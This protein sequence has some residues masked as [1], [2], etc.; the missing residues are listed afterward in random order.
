[1]EIKNNFLTILLLVSV[2]AVA[3][4]LIV[5][6]NYAE[7][8]TV[9][10]EKLGS[11]HLTCKDGTKLKIEDVELDAKTDTEGKWSGTLSISESSQ[12]A[13]WKINEGKLSGEKYEFK[14]TAEDTTGDCPD[15]KGTKATVKGS[16]GDDVSIKLESEVGTVYDAKA[17]VK[18]TQ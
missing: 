8:A 3:T 18:C 5:G 15:E 4:H 7:A 6:N 11:G 2:F 1:M 10:T 17:T 9:K 13:D 12:G 16:C 14:T